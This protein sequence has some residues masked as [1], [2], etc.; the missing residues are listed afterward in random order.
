MPNPKA[1]KCH[2]SQNL[3]AAL[4]GPSRAWRLMLPLRPLPSPAH[5]VE[6]S[7]HGYVFVGD[8]SHPQTEGVTNI[9]LNLTVNFH[10]ART[11]GSAIQFTH[12]LRGGLSLRRI[13]QKFK[14]LRERPRS[15]RVPFSS[16]C[17]PR[18][19]LIHPFIHSQSLLTAGLVTGTKDASVS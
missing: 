2:V 12:F 11:A 10:L 6:L 8:A 5:Q 18:I 17:S 16:Y 4:S 15:E 9:K 14:K 13:P 1:W 7:S 3:G 19:A